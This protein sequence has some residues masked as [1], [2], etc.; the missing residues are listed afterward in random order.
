MP[1]SPAKV[2]WVGSQKSFVVESTSFRSEVGHGRHHLL[3]DLGL[4]E[5]EVL[6]ERALERVKALQV[7]PSGAVD[8]LAQLRVVALEA[9]SELGLALVK[10]LR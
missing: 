7:G 10:R 9:C 2:C 4:L 5:R 3:V 1:E 8:V 6:G